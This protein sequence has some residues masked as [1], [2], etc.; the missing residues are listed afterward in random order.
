[1]E[2]QHLMVLGQGKEQV[3]TKACVKETENGWRWRQRASGGPAP[4]FREHLSSTDYKISFYGL[5]E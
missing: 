2:Q 4:A 5:K 3:E 1:M